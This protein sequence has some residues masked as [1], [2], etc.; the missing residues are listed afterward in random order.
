MDIAGLWRLFW[1]TGDIR[2]YLAARMLKNEREEART[3]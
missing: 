1:A 3:A 2:F